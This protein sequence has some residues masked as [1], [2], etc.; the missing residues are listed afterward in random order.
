M[1]DFWCFTPSPSLD[2]SKRVESVETATRSVLWPQQTRIEREHALLTKGKLKLECREI[3]SFGQV[4]TVSTG[5]EF[6]STFN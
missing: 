6:P 3:D 1:K 4:G 5:L 2:V